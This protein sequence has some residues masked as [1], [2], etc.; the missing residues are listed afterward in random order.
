MLPQRGKPGSASTRRWS[1]LPFCVLLLATATDVF[2]LETIVLHDGVSRYELGRSIET[3]EDPAADLTIHRVATPEYASTFRPSERLVPN[4]GITESAYWVRFR[5]EQAD[6]LPTSTPEREA[7]AESWLLEFG[8]PI[9]DVVDLYVPLP[10]GGFEVRRSGESRPFD[11]REIRYRNPVFRLPRSAGAQTFFLRA[12]GDDTRRLPLTVWS[13]AAFDAH[14]TVDTYV[15]GLL[16]GA[17]AI[18]SVYNGLLFWGTRDHVYLAYAAVLAAFEFYWMSYTGVL[19]QFFLPGSPHLAM[20]PL[21][22]GGGLLLLTLLYFSRYYLATKTTVPRIDRFLRVLVAFS[23]GICFWPLFGHLFAFQRAILVLCFVIGATLIWGAICAVRAG[24]RPAQ[25]YL[26]GWSWVIFVGLIALV[27]GFGAEI[28]ALHADR[29]FPVAFLVTLLTASLGITYRLRWLESQA[30][31]AAE[32]RTRQQS[33]LAHALRLS[34][35]G[36]LASTLAHEINQPLAAI[37]NFANGCKRHLDRG[38]AD[39]QVIQARLDDIVSQALRGSDIIRALTNFTRKHER[40]YERLEI[41]D[42]LEEALSLA[43]IEPGAKQA[44]VHLRIDP[45]LPPVVADRVLLQQVFVNIARNAFEAMEGMDNGRGTLDIQ[46]SRAGAHGIDVTFSDT[47]HGIRAELMESIFDSFV[48]TKKDGLGMGLAISK[49]IVEDH[50]GRL[51]LSSDTA[52]G[53]GATV[54]VRLPLG[55]PE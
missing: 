26:I 8:S 23:A 15:M 36:E 34:T 22:I 5:L 47:G 3:L 6:T 18:F 17:L 25:F 7:S 13:S 19:A 28:P 20:A 46:A 24:Y 31:G 16:F 44:A 12:A 37:V 40:K 48:T 49:S 50:G 9:T 10:S 39:L 41:H 30:R 32:Q 11:S 54:R 33:E 52:T 27:A 29:V 42:V 21:H 45:G 43:V 55:Q 4:F 53:S 38:S 2:A 35:M 51:E 14:R 1:A